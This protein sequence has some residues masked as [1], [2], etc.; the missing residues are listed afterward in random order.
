MAKNVNSVNKLNVLINKQHQ[1]KDQ[2]ERKNMKHKKS[3][4]MP[5]TEA[6]C[7]FST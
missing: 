7:K 5:I 3:E 6:A 1:M 4:T 2:D